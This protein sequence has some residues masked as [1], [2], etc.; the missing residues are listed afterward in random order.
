MRVSTGGTALKGSITACCFPWLWP[1]S[2][3]S[4][5]V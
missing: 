2:C 5:G 4:G 3:P 1:K